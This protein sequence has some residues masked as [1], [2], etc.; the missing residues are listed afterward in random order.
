MSLKLRP[1][2]NPITTQNKLSPEVTENL[3]SLLGLLVGVEVVPAREHANTIKANN[4]LEK[5]INSLNEIND[6]YLKLICRLLP[7]V[8]YRGKWKILTKSIEQRTK[9][10]KQHKLDKIPENISPEMRK[11]LSEAFQCY[12]LNLRMASY[13][14]ILRSIE[15]GVNELYDKHNPPTFNENKGKYDFVNAKIKLDWIE[16]Q[17]IIKGA[18]YRIAK[19]FIE[20]RNEAV[21]EIYEP[22]D[23]Q[24]FSAIET[25][26]GIIDKLN[27]NE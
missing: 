6:R 5:D 2:N 24:I 4:Q 17:K 3:V 23:L 8:D 15:I 19:S 13:I 14:M 10:L 1:L 26:I 11:N 18:D 7:Y 27:K 22:T 16:K 12:I 25:V 20:S 21:H 9:K